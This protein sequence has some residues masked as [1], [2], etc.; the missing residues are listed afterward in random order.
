MRDGRASL[1]EKLAICRSSVDLPEP[2][3][4]ISA[5]ISPGAIARSMSSSPLRPF[6]NVF[7]RRSMRMA[8]MALPSK[9]RPIRPESG[10]TPLYARAMTIR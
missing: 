6:G 5:T 1:D 7:D 3:A 2:D 9:D 4:P 10:C 8:S